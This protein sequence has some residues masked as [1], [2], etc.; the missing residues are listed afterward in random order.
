M[1]L[2][3]IIEK[4]TKEFSGDEMSGGEKEEENNASINS[5]RDSVLVSLCLALTLLARRTLATA[6]H[7]ASSLGVEYFLHGLHS[8]FKGYFN[9][10]LFPLEH[11][12]FCSVHWNN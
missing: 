7:S 8:L 6:S 9:I 5:S 10:F 2:N 4:N 11:N 1:A 3:S 12:S